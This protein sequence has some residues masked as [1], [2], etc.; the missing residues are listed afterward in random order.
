MIIKLLGVVKMFEYICCK[1]GKKF[2]VEIPWCRNVQPICLNCALDE[3][4]DYD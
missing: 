4:E 3:L 2:T 1:C